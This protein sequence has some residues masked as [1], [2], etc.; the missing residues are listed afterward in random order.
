M[1][2]C[3]WKKTMTT[4]KVECE[5][6]SYLE[7]A[8][9]PCCVVAISDSMLFISLRSCSTCRFLTA[10]SCR[11][12]CGSCLEQTLDA[13]AFTTPRT[14]PHTSKTGCCYRIWPTDLHAI[15][16]SPTRPVVTECDWTWVIICLGSFF[17]VVI[18]CLVIVFHWIS[19]YSFSFMLVSV[20]YI[21]MYFS[22]L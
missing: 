3:K 10:T 14:Q 1:R 11:N 7:S 18:L 8:L 15:S 9:R 5:C 19:V 4:M 21:V 2:W 17:A 13:T 12:T 16:P 22:Q 20:Y 6:G